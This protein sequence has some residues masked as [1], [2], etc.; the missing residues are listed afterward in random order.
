MKLKKIES[1]Q[2]PKPIRGRV[3]AIPPAWQR[4]TPCYL[5]F[6]SVNTEGMRGRRLAD[7]GEDYFCCY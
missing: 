1:A 7:R 2:L 4:G 6:D 5:L 3:R